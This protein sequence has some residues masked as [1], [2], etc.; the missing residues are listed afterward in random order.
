M[1]PAGAAVP[2]F[3]TALEDLY[4]KSPR[5]ALRLMAR[6]L[7]AHRTEIDELRRQISELK[8]ELEGVQHA[9]DGRRAREDG[10]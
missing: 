7:L 5:D 9:G 8:G 4:R 3:E 2:G 1:T 6:D 10:R